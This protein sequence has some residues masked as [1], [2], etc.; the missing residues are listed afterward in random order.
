M[1]AGTDHTPQH[2][3]VDR[4]LLHPHILRAFQRQGWTV[5]Y[6]PRRQFLLT[7]PALCYFGEGQGTREEED[8]L[9]QVHMT[10]QHFPH[11]SEVTRQPLEETIESR[12]PDQEQGPGATTDV[13][14]VK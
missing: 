6:Q 10:L 3:I 14:K 8:V 9:E 2:R 7:G 12:W 11:N 5:K 4:S 1:T 13:R